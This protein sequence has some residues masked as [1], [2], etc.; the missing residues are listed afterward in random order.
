MTESQTVTIT[1]TDLGGNTTR[2][3]VEIR[4][5]DEERF[6]AICHKANAVRT[7]RFDRVT[8]V[9][10]YN[11]QPI[12]RDTWVKTVSGRDIPYREPSR[13]HMAEKDGRISVMF[14]G[15]GKADRAYAEALAEQHDLRVIKSTFGARLGFLV[16]GDTP[17]GSKISKAERLGIQILFYE[18]FLKL[19]ETGELPY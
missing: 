9:E 7:F 13:A 18:D 15:F 11:W 12:D 17:G 5:A 1:Y 14:T 4:S 19:L 16:V 10:S 8:A 2:R 3:S 6:E